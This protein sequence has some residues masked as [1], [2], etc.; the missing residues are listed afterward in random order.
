[1]ILR[2][3]GRFVSHAY[4]L[5]SPAAPVDVERNSQVIWYSMNSLDL[6]YDAK[7]HENR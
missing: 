7:R 1:M 3:S 4:R 2:L 6:E 5:I